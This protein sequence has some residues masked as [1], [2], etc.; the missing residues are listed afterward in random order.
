MF[1]AFET[2]V[3]MIISKKK[4]GNDFKKNLPMNIT[5]RQLFNMTIFVK[6]LH[7]IPEDKLN[8]YKIAATTLEHL[9]LD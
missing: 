3:K 6:G 8:A 9:K 5:F 1:I 2:T 7:Y 4:G